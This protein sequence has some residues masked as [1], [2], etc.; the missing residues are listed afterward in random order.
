MVVKKVGVVVNN[1]I[2][3]LLKIQSSPLTSSYWIAK[4]LLKIKGGSAL[5]P[6]L[7]FL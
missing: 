4:G 3:N 5:L 1:E 2:Q 7:I 6:L